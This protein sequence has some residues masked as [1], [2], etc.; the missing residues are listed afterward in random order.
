MNQI[1]RVERQ[2]G[3]YTYSLY[4]VYSGESV[5]VQIDSDKI[6]LCPDRSIFAQWPEACPFLRKDPRQKKI[7]CIVHR[8]RPELCREFGCWRLLILDAAGN[9]CGRIMGTRHLS[10]EDPSL[11]KLWEAEANNIRMLED[12]SWDKAVIRILETYGYQVMSSE[13]KSSG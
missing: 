12:D 13:T 4:N 10:A 11:L 8:T 9:R 5:L 2:V 6:S 7:V 1:H 3:E